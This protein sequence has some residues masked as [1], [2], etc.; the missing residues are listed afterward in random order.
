MGRDALRHMFQR[1][2]ARLWSPAISEPCT[3][4][5]QEWADV[6]SP[7]WLAEERDHVRLADGRMARTLAVVAYPRRVEAG[8][9]RPLY[10]F[11][12]EMRLACH[13]E[14]VDTA[15]AVEQLTRHAR[16]LRA[17]I[18]LSEA[19]RVQRDA[20]DEAALEDAVS[21]RDALA[22]GRVRLF[23]YHLTA[24]LLAPDR[25][26]LDRLTAALIAEMESRLLLTRACVYQQ[27]DGFV[28]TLPLGRIALPCARNLDSEALA[29]TL[30]FVGG[31][32]QLP[33][34]EVW[35]RDL[36][37]HCLVAVPRWQAANAHVICVAA[38]G[39]GKS[40]WLKS[41]LAQSLLSGRTAIVFDPQG[42]YAR[43]CH[44]LGGR[45]VV[46]GP[47]AGG[48]VHPV[49]PR[50]RA[51]ARPADAGG[52]R[53]ASAATAAWRAVCAERL[54]G[55][56]QLLGPAAPAERNAA[57]AA[58]EEASRAP[59]GGSLERVLAALRA[60]GDAAAPVAA[61]LRVALD[62]GLSAFAGPE[63]MPQDAPLLVFDVSPIV[64]RAPAVA[65][66]AYYL[67]AE[68][69]LD[70]ATAGGPPLT[71]AVD[72]AHHLLAHAP[73]ARLVERLFRTGRKLR[74]G[75][76][77]VTQSVGDLLGEQADADAARATRAA[78]ANATTAFLMRQQNA[79]EVQWL[80]RLYRLSPEDAEWLL[81]CRQGEGLALS[82]DRRARTRVEAPADLH[83]LLASG[84]PARA[85]PVPP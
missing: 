39:A 59:D 55:A 76:C 24:T 65:A 45:L 22:R 9:L 51:A 53:D 66:A 14:P 81:N 36:R 11:P 38:S 25:E 37:H 54:A 68:S 62:A 74:V 13:I 26:T 29:T 8:W 44:A 19:R 79:R 71:V 70:R 27:A 57:W 15:L 73:T 49:P 32:F 52:G 83:D 2:R 7:D 75:V 67:L 47:A 78:L 23:R 20:Y 41:L 3:A 46:L 33:A 82:G 60:G 84:A 4:G 42:E 69:V 6:L 72:E 63:G 17:S 5:R 64:R 40:F 35:G 18:L 77:L 80:Q 56:L 34:D 10:A 16:T 1:A 61:R 43:W 85:G 28:H 48:R 58:A 31:E 21:L 30:P 12:A 50:P